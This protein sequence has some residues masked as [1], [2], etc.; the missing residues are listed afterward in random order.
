MSKLR[1]LHWSGAFCYDTARSTCHVLGGFAA[2]VSGPATIKLRD[3][4]L[5][6]REQNRVTCKRCL[7]LM[8][9]RVHCRAHPE[10]CCGRKEQLS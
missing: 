10:A 9:K 4:G 3:E 6:T 7:A 1:K 2:C 5:V 8:A